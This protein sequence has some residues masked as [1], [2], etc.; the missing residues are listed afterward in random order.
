MRFVKTSSCLALVAAMCSGCLL[1]VEHNATSPGARG[2]VLD[3][4]T[5]APLVGANVVVSG[6]GTWSRQIFQMLLPTRDH[7]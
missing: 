3:A 6:C 4:E 5:R 2:V 7:L 1:R